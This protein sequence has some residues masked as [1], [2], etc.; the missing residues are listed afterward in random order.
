MAVG[1]EQEYFDELH[2]AEDMGLLFEVFG[3][4]RMTGRVWGALMAT[5]EPQLSAADLAER[6]HASSG[7]ISAATRTLLRLGLIDRTRVAGERRDYFLVRPGAINR[8]ARQRFAVLNAAVELADQ[9]LEHF[10]DRPRAR[11]RLQ[12]MRDVYAW[13]AAQLTVLFDRWDREHAP[14]YRTE[15]GGSAADPSEPSEGGDSS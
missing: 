9:G 7:S 15:A 5:D 13:Y 10:A 3:V 12:E 1:S 8:L 2:F 14:R 4:S 11:E 6:L